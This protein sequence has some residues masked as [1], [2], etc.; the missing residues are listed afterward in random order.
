TKSYALHT[1]DNSTLESDSNSGLLVR[2]EF[3]LMHESLDT[4]A[5]A[6]LVAARRDDATSARRTLVVRYETRSNSLI[7]IQACGLLTRPLFVPFI[8]RGA[9]GSKWAASA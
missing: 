9:A 2:C 3:S 4:L 7:R 1:A 6:T 8:S 5:L